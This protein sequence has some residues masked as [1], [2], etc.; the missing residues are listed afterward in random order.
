LRCAVKAVS[1]ISK[2]LIKSG[3]CQPQ[4][5]QKQSVDLILADKKIFL[6][7]IRKRFGYKYIPMKAFPRLT[8]RMVIFCG[9]I[10]LGATVARSQTGGDYQIFVSNE[11]SGNLTVISGK[12]FKVVAI[13]PV[14]KRP[15]GI[16]ASPD[17]KTVY[18][19]LSGTPI[20]P[21]PKLDANGNP[22][23]EKGHDDD[24]D[25]NVKSDKAA[26][27]I[28]L[29]DVAQKKFLRKIP[30]GS[31][32]EQFCLSADGTRLYIAN[33]DVGTATVLEAATGKTITFIPVTREP[34][35]T[36]V[37]PDGKFFY[38][39]CETAGDVFAIDTQT[40]KIIGH[41]QVHPRPRNVDFLPDG[42][43]AFIPSE[44]VGELNV[45]DTASQKLVKVITLP[46]HSRPQ[47]VRVSPDGKK[48]YVSDG[49]AG[50]VSVV[51]AHTYAVLNTIKVGKR[52]WG[53]T[54]SP[55]GKYLFTANGPS[56]DVSVVDLVTEKEVARVKSP[57]S[58]W[59]IVAVPNAK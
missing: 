32:P 12:D 21:P 41:L 36:G 19:A 50:T 46:P 28:G 2:T 38:I 40:F 58:P 55:D 53:I 43:R 35:G 16:H 23:F 48:I 51:D 59:G 5:G 31:D 47:C 56:D 6:L 37:S 33:E 18:V 8:L 9:T 54:F 34:E 13:I 27:G 30:A 49:R 3:H 24:D 17:G 15:R 52:P 39:T 7:T 4:S 20:E 11:K 22:V 45:I 57:G 14:G 29:V 25:D 1:P 10:F 44:S 26:D 42:S